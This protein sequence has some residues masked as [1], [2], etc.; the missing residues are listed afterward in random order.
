MITKTEAKEIINGLFL[1]QALAIGGLVALHPTDDA[2][3]WGLIRNLDAIRGRML[4]RIEGPNE[5]MAALDLT[6]HPAIEDFILSLR[7]G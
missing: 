1:E 5:E 2:L 4:Q 7:R 6:P 3:V